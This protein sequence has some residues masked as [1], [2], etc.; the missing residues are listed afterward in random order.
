METDKPVTLR[1]VTEENFRAV[2]NLHVG[3]DQTHFVASNLYSLAEAYINPHFI[4]RAIYA[5]DD[6]VG[7]AMYTLE[8]GEYW[9]FRLMV[10][11]EYQHQGYGRQAMQLV[12]AQLRLNADCRRIFISYEP[13][14][15]GAKTL[16]ASLGFIPTG[17][18]IGGEEVAC[19]E[20]A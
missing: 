4:P 5:G 17:A 13:E 15:I 19:L 16:Y 18:V 8:K 1:P 3:E 14:N 9:I 20:F 7:F 11:A 12:I 2:V 10:A 6:L